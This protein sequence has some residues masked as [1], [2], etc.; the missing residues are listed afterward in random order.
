[1]STKRDHRWIRTLWT[2]EFE[3][4]WDWCRWQWTSSFSDTYQ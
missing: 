3:C 2:Y 4:L 1:M